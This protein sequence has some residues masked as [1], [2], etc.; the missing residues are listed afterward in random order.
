[1]EYQDDD[2]EY[3]RPARKT[4]QEALTSESLIPKMEFKF[5]QTF[6]RTALQGRPEEMRKAVEA[7][8]LSQRR[9]MVEDY[10]NET[11]R[12]VLNEAAAGK[13]VYHRELYFPPRDC[14]RDDILQGFQQKFPLCTVTLEDV[15]VEDEG[16]PA[17]KGHVRR[18][19]KPGIK[20]DWS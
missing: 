6:S 9:Q 12:A 5:A 1:M 2:R 4:E 18:T 14:T 13:S 15:C 20:I 10:V 16:Y 17:P 7:V 11:E 8:K 19:M 3:I